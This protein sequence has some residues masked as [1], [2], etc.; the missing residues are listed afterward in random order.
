MPAGQIRSAGDRQGSPQLGVP[1]VVVRL[2]AI[3]SSYLGQTAANLRRTF[4][5][6]ASAQWVVLF[7]EFQAL[8]RQRND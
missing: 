5:Y 3:V 4:D 1:L 8:G 7:D 6:A 2:D